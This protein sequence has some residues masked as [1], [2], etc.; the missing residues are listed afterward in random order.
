MDA[1][2]DS[3]NFY[4]LPPSEEKKPGANE[5][6]QSF[7]L[8]FF[9]KLGAEIKF[10]SGYYVINKVPE[11][12]EKFFGKQS[13]YFFALSGGNFPKEVEIINQGN[14]LIKSINGFLEG[15][16]ETTLVK[17]NIDVD[18]VSELEKRFNF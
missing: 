12:F 7:C 11:S 13:P 3:K 1:E 4:T 14:H 17:L 16:G 18:P 2:K 8:R 9:E 6:I 5:K 15:S 10:L